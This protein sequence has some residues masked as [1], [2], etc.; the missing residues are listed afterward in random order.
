M[1]VVQCPRILNIILRIFLRDCVGTAANW[2]RYITDIKP[3]VKPVLPVAA[4]RFPTLLINLNPL[5]NSL[6]V[7]RSNSLN[8]P[9]R[10]LF[11]FL[12]FIFASPFYT[13]YFRNTW[14]FSV[15]LSL[16][17]WCFCN[18]FFFNTS[19]FFIQRQLHR[20]RRS[21]SCVWSSWLFRSSVLSLVPET[22][23]SFVCSFGLAA[24]CRLDFSSS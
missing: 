6:A 14:D 18:C 2:F 17:R 21:L 1:P 4:T 16:K 8:L 3:E 19:N 11:F 24:P 20:L 23:Q 22:Y 15:S 5:C 9:N 13:R 7:R 10:H 12:S